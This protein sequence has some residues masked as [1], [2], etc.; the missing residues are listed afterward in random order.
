MK[1]L[2]FIL[3]ASLANRL[4]AQELFVFTEPAS[5][6]AAKS[7]GVRDINAFMFEDD[8]TL[9]YH[10]MPELMWG[11]NKNWMLHTQAF[12]SNRQGGGLDAEGGSLYAKYRFLSND[13]L[14]SHFR[15]AAFAR[16][17]LNKADIH[18]QE[19]ETMGHNTGYELGLIA[20]Q[21]LHKVAIS[22][23]VSYERAL[24]NGSLNP[25]PVGQSNDAINYTL[26]AGKLMLPKKY[27]SFDQTNVNLMV[28]V[29]GQ[30]LNGNGLSYLD[31][32]PSVQFII[33]SQARI[34]IAWRQQL[35]STMQRTAPN[36]LLL[37]LEYNFFNIFR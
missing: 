33:R 17:S 24:D 30:H 21:L 3:I 7:L 25:F 23:S 14:Q 29:L 37:K 18:Q 9:N 6:M 1:W 35:Y 11:I 36:G 13:D 27:S 31:I 10:N 19:I 2:L 12:I 32:A 8:G 20:T 5:N 22:S 15:M 28:E 34:D 4:Q 26:S 16:Y